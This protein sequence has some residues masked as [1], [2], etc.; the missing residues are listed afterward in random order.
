MGSKKLSQFFNCF[1][2]RCR[3]HLYHFWPFRVRIHNNEEHFLQEWSSE[4]NVYPLPGTSWP[5][6]R[7]QWCGF[8]VF[9]GE[10]TA[11][12]FFCHLFNCFIHRRPPH[13]ASGQGFHFNNTTVTTMEFIQYLYLVLLMG[14][15]RVFPTSGSCLGQ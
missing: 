15:S 5:F 9:L 11:R 7:V 12:A 13:V 3:I 4:I 8:R 1:R 2:G 14:L 10:L 6:P